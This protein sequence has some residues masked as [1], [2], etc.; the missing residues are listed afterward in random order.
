[1]S[2]CDQIIGN[3]GHFSIKFYLGKIL[4]DVSSNEGNWYLENK[5][6]VVLAIRILIIFRSYT[7]D[8]N[9][10][11]FILLFQGESRPKQGCSELMSHC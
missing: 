3:I 7:C 9:H 11:P 8:N 6:W 5:S 10:L 4:I 1:M 2:V